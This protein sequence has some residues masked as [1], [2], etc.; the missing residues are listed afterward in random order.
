MDVK[1]YVEQTPMVVFG[2]AANADDKV[3]PLVGSGCARAPLIC[4]MVSCI[5]AH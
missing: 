5:R 4:V 1:T 2:L 3:E